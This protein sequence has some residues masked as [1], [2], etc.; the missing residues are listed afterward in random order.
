MNPRNRTTTL[1]LDQQ[2]LEGIQR[3]LQTMPTLYL[4]GETFTP[5]TLEARIQARV[6]AA[7]AILAAKAAWL[8][9]VTTYE[10]LDK[11]TSLLVHDLK[12]LVLAAFGQ[13][14]PK[15]ADFGF[16]A[17][18]RTPLTE[19]QKEA[20][21]AKR[22]ATRLARKTLGPKAKLAITGATPKPPTS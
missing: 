2:V 11:Q 3:D 10:A 9:T 15:V 20:A 19:A 13:D 16:T 8:A 7:N 21:V 17:P 1:G 6:D 5:A 4:G 22:K 12:Q 18:K 14:S